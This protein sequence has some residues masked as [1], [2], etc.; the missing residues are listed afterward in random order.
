MLKIDKLSY[1]F[2]QKDL[3]KE[4]SFTLEEGQHCAFIGT[5]GTGKS[6]L[7]QMIMNPDEY[8]FEGKLQMSPDHRIGYV[9]QFSQVN[10]TD[11]MTV[12]DYISEPFVRQQEEVNR[13][14]AEME[15]AEDMDELLE[16]YQEAWD[17]FTAMDGDNYEVNIKKQLKLAGLE[18]LENTDVQKISG[19]EFKLIQIIR[20]MSTLPGLLIMD[21][22]DV[23]LDFE[24]LNAL[25]ELINAHKGTLLVITHNRYLL[26]HCFNK[27]LHL[28]NMEIQEFDG[29]YREY[30]FAL[31][32][33]KIE[34]QE[35]SV[36]DQEEIA[37]NE[38]LVNHLRA[39]ATAVD[40]ATRGKQLKARVSQLK[41]LQERQIKAPFVEIPHPEI[42]LH[43]T[44][45]IG[46]AACQE[47]VADKIAG[48]DMAVNETIE[49]KTI[50]TVQD[51][52]VS[53]DKQLL[54]NVTFAIGARDRVAIVGGNG[55]G[56]TTLLRDI[57]RHESNA[58]TLEPEVELAYLSQQQ[59]ETLR[60]DQTILETMDATGLETPAEVEAYLAPYGFSQEMLNQ[61]ICS[62]S[63]GEKNLLQLAILSRGDANLLLLDE[64][65]SHLDTYAQESLEEAVASYNGAVLMVSHD[66]YTIANC[67]D[68]VLYVDE[69]TVRKVSGRKFR[70]MIYANHFDKDYLEKEQNKKEL[71]GRIYRALNKKDYESAKKIAEDLEKIVESM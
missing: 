3:Y 7:I 32:V 16:Q 35:Q 34:L 41:R 42:Y 48:D 12:F 26:N 54:E 61:K 60:E 1:S 18:G 28:E 63:G 6:T 10:Q 15:N 21:E 51:Y 47:D 44:H 52:S 4:I 46:T 40:N 31:L 59:G 45:V 19:G 20:E 17:T 30:N 49:S 22:P 70:K 50:L 71:E 2:P 43:T 58:I 66:F 8:M 62:L 36:K 39:R 27:I 25:R 13:I 56:K 69:K 67:V 5:N 23:F 33:K 64:P 37:R 68:Y 38:K 53:F 14:C 29:N 9:S 24:N 65:T 57:V 11:D 55:T